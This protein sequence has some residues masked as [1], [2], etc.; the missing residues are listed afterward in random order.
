MLVF[1]KDDTRVCIRKDSIQV[2]YLVDVSEMENST[3]GLI[4]DLNIFT[5]GHNLQELLTAERDSI[6]SFFYRHYQQLGE[7]SLIEEMKALG[8]QFYRLPMHNVRYRDLDSTH[9]SAVAESQANYLSASRKEMGTA[10]THKRQLC[11]RFASE[12]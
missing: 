3:S 5:Y 1:R 9:T 4:R 8:F 11:Y 2:D 10:S 12:E 7:H 6:R